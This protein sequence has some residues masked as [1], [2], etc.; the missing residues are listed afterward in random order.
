MTS[1]RLAEGFAQLSL[2]F[3]EPVQVQ[4]GK[5]IVLDLETQKS[6]DEVGGRNATRELKV[7]LGVVYDFTTDSY[8]TYFEQDV[9]EMVADVFSSELVVGYNLVKFDYTVLSAYS[10]RDFQAV[11]TL[12]MFL[13]VEERIGFRVKLDNLVSCTIGNHK[14]GDGL[15]A[16]EW[17]KTGEWGKLEH[18]C[19]EDVRLTK[20]LY[21]FG[22]K[23]GYV[24]YED[25]NTGAMARVPVQW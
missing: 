11:R 25:F 3:E 2:D 20:E 13:D 6:F 17:F 9:D 18:Y 19:K 16:I 15:Q 21:E 7:S 22:K 14:A 4:R 24:N 1:S 23:H 5:V 8:R 12:D 10:H